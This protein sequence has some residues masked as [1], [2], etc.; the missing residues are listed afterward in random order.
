MNKKLHP[1][2]LQID[3]AHQLCTT[4]EQLSLRMRQARLVTRTLIEAAH[5]IRATSEQLRKRTEQAAL[6]KD[7]EA[8]APSPIET[9]QGLPG[10]SLIVCTSSMAPYAMSLRFTWICPP[11]S[12]ILSHEA[13]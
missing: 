8:A 11:P 10:N 5:S 1:Y 12:E 3:K 9:V 2:R 7:N 6:D 13:S 4:T